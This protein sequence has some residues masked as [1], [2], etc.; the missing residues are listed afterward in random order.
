[1]LTVIATS[2]VAM[3]ISVTSNILYVLLSIKLYV[4]PQQMWPSL[5]KPSLSAH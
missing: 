4:V 3:Y 5:Q 2:N 1:M